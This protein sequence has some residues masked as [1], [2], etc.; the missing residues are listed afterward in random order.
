MHHLAKLPARGVEL[1]GCQDQLWW[2]CDGWQG[3]TV[4]SM[5][6]A[7]LKR[8]KWWVVN[9]IVHVW[10]CV[11]L[12]IVTP[13]YRPPV[14]IIATCMS[15]NSLS[16][17]HQSLATQESQ[18]SSYHIASCF[19]VKISKYCS[20]MVLTWFLH[21]HDLHIDM[22]HIHRYLDTTSNILRVRLRLISTILQTFICPESVEKKVGHVL[23]EMEIW[24]GTIF[25]CMY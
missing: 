5:H 12:H 20:H 11:M 14:G 18:F 17:Q 22:Y 13:C 19:T 25:R 3:Q 9:M 7:V 2:P 23:S 21:V 15:S 24:K 1:L 6:L 16:L 4:S 10:C 8:K